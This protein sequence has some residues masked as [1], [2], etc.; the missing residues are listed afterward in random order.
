M[1]KLMI[2]NA[3][4]TRTSAERTTPDSVNPASF[5]LGARPW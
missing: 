1:S 5:E 3:M 4:R 2:S